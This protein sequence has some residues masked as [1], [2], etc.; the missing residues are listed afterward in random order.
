MLYLLAFLIGVAVG[1]LF[2]NQIFGLLAALIAALD[3]AWDWW[4]YSGRIYLLRAWFALVDGWRRMKQVFAKKTDTLRKKLIVLLVVLFYI[5]WAIL[6]IFFLLAYGFGWVAIAA[7]IAFA[8]ALLLIT[9]FSDFWGWLMT[10]GG[11]A[12]IMFFMAWKMLSDLFDG[13][14]NM[15]AAFW[16]GILK[17]LAGIAASLAAI[18]PSCTPEPVVPVV[19]KQAERRFEVSPALRASMRVIATV[20]AQRGDGCLKMTYRGGLQLSVAECEEISLEKSRRVERKGKFK[21]APNVARGET[22]YL[23]EEHGSRKWIIP[24]EHQ[25]R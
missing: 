14:G 1:L 9:I 11:A 23:V 3:D 7:L 10:L 21:L 20:H 8:I 19:Q 25:K 2:R 24:A 15:V 18:L 16:Q 5:V 17:G 4:L 13:F 6:G 12:A 22:W